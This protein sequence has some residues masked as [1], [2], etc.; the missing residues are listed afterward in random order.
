MSCTVGRCP[1]QKCNVYQWGLY[2]MVLPYVVAVI[3]KKKYSKI[4]LVFLFS[5]FRS[6]DFEYIERKFGAD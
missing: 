5:P 2:V 3:T 4:E 6:A 1:Q